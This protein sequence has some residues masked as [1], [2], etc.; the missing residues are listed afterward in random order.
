MSSPD[1]DDFL[2]GCDIDFAEHADDLE[3]QALRP[4]FP[5]GVPDPALAAQYLLLAASP[6][7]PPP[8]DVPTTGAPQ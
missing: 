8:D 2:D 3:T 5:D 7:L 6:D 1:D 4:L